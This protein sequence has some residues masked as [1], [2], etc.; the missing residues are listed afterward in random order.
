MING[1][2]GFHDMGGIYTKT[3]LKNIPTGAAADAAKMLA[4][5]TDLAAFVNAGIS[6]YDVLTWTETAQ[7]PTQ[8]IAVG[9]NS[10]KCAVTCRY[11]MSGTQ[12]TTVLWLPNPA[13]SALEMV[14]GSGYRLTQVAEDA[15][16]AALTA[17]AG[18]A[19]TIV[20]SKVLTKNWSNPLSRNHSSIRFQDAANQN[21]FM[22]VPRDL[23]VSSA[24][25][26]TLTTAID[27]ALVSGSSV[28][29]SYF[30]LKQSAVPDQTTMPG[31]ATN[32]ADFKAFSSVEARAVIKLMYMESGVKKYETIALPAIRRSQLDP[33]FGTVKGG[34]SKYVLQEDTGIAVADALNTFY[35]GSAKEVAFVGSKIKGKNLRDQ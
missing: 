9:L 21:G 26:I 30:L 13:D 7:A 5:A 10:M 6:H 16:T 17:C 4:L 19:V 11:A 1:V 28:T 2:I 22:G 24:K 20:D 3:V 23:C 14:D 18:F 25:L 12:K 27:A 31:L 32:D 33:P 29:G 15:M 8:A 35:G 34:K